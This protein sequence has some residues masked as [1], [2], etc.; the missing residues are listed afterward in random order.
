MQSSIYNSFNLQYGIIYRGS[1]SSQKNLLDIHLQVSP[2]FSSISRSSMLDEVA[3]P[4]DLSWF[5]YWSCWM[6]FWPLP[7]SLGILLKEFD[8]VNLKSMAMSDAMK[9][10]HTLVKLCWG[11]HRFQHVFLK[12]NEFHIV[13]YYAASILWSTGTLILSGHRCHI[14][15]VAW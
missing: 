3:D 1:I 6:F 12:T 11:D 9:I 13:P 14:Y 5:T 10:T 4:K 8:W 7:H 15:H 2:S